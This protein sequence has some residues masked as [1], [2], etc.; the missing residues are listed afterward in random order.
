VSPVIPVPPAI[1]VGYALPVPASLVAANPRLIGEGAPA[2][3]RSVPA[4]PVRLAVTV[5]TTVDAVTAGTVRVIAPPGAGTSTI[6]LSGADGAVYTYRDVIARVAGRTKVTAGT[7]IGVS[8]PGGLTFSVSVPD[9]RGPVDAAEA[10]AAWAAGVSVDVRALPSTVAPATA[11]ARSQVLLVTDAGAGATAA[12]LARSLAGPLVAV[13]TQT[14]SDSRSPSGQA[15]TARQT[16]RQTALQVSL[17]VSRQVATEGGRLLLVVL[18]NGTPAQAAALAARLPTGR[19]VLWVAPPGTTR[20]QAAAYRAIVAARPGFRVESLPP[21]LTAA[22][23]PANAAPNAATNAA[24]NAATNA[25]PNAATN[26]PAAQRWSPTGALAT[27]QLAATYAST[28]YWLQSESTQARTVVSWAEQQLGKPYKYAAA[29][30]DN[31]DCSGLTM[32]A[33][34]QAGITVTHN[35]NAQWLQTRS[36]PVAENQLALGDLVFFAG[37]DGT[38][39][40]PG[41]VGIYVGNGEIIDAPYTGALVRFDPLASIGGYVGATDPYAPRAP[42][43]TVPAGGIGVPAFAGGASAPAA[44][45]ALN[46]YQSFANSLTTATWGP[47]QFAYLNLLWQR[48]SGWNPAATNPVSGAFGI[49][50]ALPAAKMASAGLDWATDPYTQIIWGIDYIRA[51]YGTPQAAWAH[52]LAFNWY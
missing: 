32:D 7:R 25:A 50:Q 13:R 34:A 40:A 18:A 36:H 22:D 41:H 45:G 8:G 39:T 19:E 11:P 30:P 27:A 17:Q 49:P 48:E 12:D 46:Q 43:A 47:G 28:A 16:A 51:T 31:F 6:V 3:R 52:E 38:L 10:L 26:A 33:L 42:G 24:P 37:S 9:V 5:G 15:A 14:I 35:A 23:A 4:G 20:Q 21:A 29:G 2:P 44:P 1:A